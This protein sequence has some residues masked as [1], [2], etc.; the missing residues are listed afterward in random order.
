M[1]KQLSCIILYE[2]DEIMNLLTRIIWPPSNY[3]CAKNVNQQRHAIH[4]EIRRQN[5]GQSYLKLA[6]EKTASQ[7]SCEGLGNSSSTVTHSKSFTC[8]LKLQP[9]K[10]PFCGFRFR[11]HA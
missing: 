10:S 11:R 9:L 5:S 7:S 1:D 2:N 8:T 4:K 3:K 6:G